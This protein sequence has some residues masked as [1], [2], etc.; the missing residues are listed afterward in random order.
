MLSTLVVATA[1]AFTISGPSS[2]YGGPCDSGDNNI[3]KYAPSDYNR[4]PGIAMRTSHTVRRTF[5]LRGSNNRLVVVWHSDYGP[6][7]FTGKLVDVNYTAV[8][9]LGYPGP[10]AWSYPTPSTVWLRPLDRRGA[11]WWAYKTRTTLDDK[12]IVR[13]W[14]LYKLNRS[15]QKKNLQKAKR[16]R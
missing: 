12:W 4:T 13:R 3:P 6:A 5:L 16:M 15:Q 14:V 9:G 1:A 7:L 11:S 10:C 8:M 2:W